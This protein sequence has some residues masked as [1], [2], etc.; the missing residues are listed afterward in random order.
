MIK[1]VLFDLDGVLADATEWH[2]QALNKALIK[3]GLT[4]IPYD[5][6]LKYYNGLPTATKIEKMR[7]RGIDISPDLEKE[8]RAQKQ[9]ATVECIRDLCEPDP[10]KLELFEALSKTGCKLGVCTNAVRETLDLILTK[11]GLKGFDITLSNQDVNQP[12]P[13]PEI[14][15]EAMKRLDVSPEETLIVEDSPLGEQAARASGAYVLKV[16]GYS[17]VTAETVMRKLASVNYSDLQILIPMAGRGSRF[18]R[19]GYTLP[20][21]LIPVLEKPMIQHVID[22]LAVKGASWFFVALGD[23]IEKYPDLKNL[24]GK[25][26]SQNGYKQGAACS[27]SLAFEHLDPNKPLMVANSDQFIDMDILDFLVAGMGC[28]GAIMTFKSEH[29]KWSYAR[30]NSE[31]Y[32]DLIKEKVVISDNA[33]SG[34]YLWN[35]ASDFITGI[36]DMIEAGDTHNNEYYIAPS[37]NYCIK[38]GGKYRIMEIKRQQMWGLGTPEDLIKF[39]DHYEK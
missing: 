31:N 35:R 3:T 37:F 9:Q 16:E 21:P 13:S 25:L 17:E 39:V 11:S 15:L 38:R 12:K 27:A 1:C 5:D 7:S 2:Y 14:Y 32:V 30:V 6:H 19:V 8:I 22:N 18:T 33:T 34:I 20:K 29:P 23:H 36:H 10:E 4:P 24:P 28:D 26:I